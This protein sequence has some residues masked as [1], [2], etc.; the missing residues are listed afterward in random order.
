M[1]RNDGTIYPIKMYGTAVRSVYRFE[2]VLCCHINC[3][4]CVSIYSGSSARTTYSTLRCLIT[5]MHKQC[6]CCASIKKPIM[7]GRFELLI[8]ATTLPHIDR[9]RQHRGFVANGTN[10]PQIALN[11]PGQKLFIM[12]LMLQM[13]SRTTCEE[14]SYH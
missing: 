14:M 10:F 3:K 8:C 4:D 7:S 2:G 12:L 13:F 6:W 9:G 1:R 11:Y 5:N